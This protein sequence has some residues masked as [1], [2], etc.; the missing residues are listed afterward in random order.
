MGERQWSV[1]MS[2]VVLPT[3]GETISQ[4]YYLSLPS[5]CSDGMGQGFTRER[6]GPGRMW[7]AGRM[8]GQERPIGVTV[9]Q[10][11]WK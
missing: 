11:R 2:A 3:Q 4:W 7:Q 6:D 5:T 8:D 10:K 1:P 9:M